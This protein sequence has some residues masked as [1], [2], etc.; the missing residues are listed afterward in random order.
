LGYVSDLSRHISKDD[1]ITLVQV[2]KTKMTKIEMLMEH[3]AYGSPHAEDEDW[4]VGKFPRALEEQMDGGSPN[5]QSEQLPDSFQDQRL[6]AD[7]ITAR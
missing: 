2:R 3:P 4:K 7:R 6:Q 1:I 5:P